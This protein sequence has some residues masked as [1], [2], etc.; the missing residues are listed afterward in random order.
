MEVKGRLKKNLEMQKSYKDVFEPVTGETL[1]RLASRK[2]F[3][4]LESPLKIGKESNIFSAIAEVDNKTERVAIKIYRILEC[5]FKRMGHYLEMDDRFRTMKSRRAIIM[6]WAKREYKNLLKAHKAGISVPKPIAQ[7]NNVLIMEFIGEK[8]PEKQPIVA[9][10]LKDKCDNPEEMFKK[11]VLNM[12]LLYQKARLVHGD[13]S[14]FNILNLNN[15]PIII[16]LSHGTPIDQARELFDRDIKNI[17]IFFNKLG[18]N[19]KEQDLINKIVEKDKNECI[20]K[21]ISKNEH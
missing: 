20:K 12:K 6:T 18:I 2:K 7:F 13:L 14:E 16:D 8:N 15:E 3:I 11:V 1:F 10:L 21:N 9:P 5:N 4:K 19:I 17:C